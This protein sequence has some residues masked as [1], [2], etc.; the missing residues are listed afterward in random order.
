MAQFNY[1]SHWK[2]V[3]ELNDK[4]LFKSALQELDVIAEN[5]SKQQHES[6]L[7]KTYIYRIRYVAE[8]EDG[9][10]ENGQVARWKTQSFSPASRAILKSI[11]AQSL[12]SYL[13]N[14]RYELY[15][16]TDVQGD[17]SM[18]VS[19]W[20]EARLHR[21]IA[22]A[23]AASLKEVDVLKKTDISK[24]DD[25]LKEGIGGTRKLRPTL[26][27][28][29]A[30]RALDY[31]KSGE[32]LITSPENQFEVTDPA[33]FAP[34]A[35]FMK[36]AFVTTDTV[37]L[38]YKALLLLQDLMRLHA[39]EKTALLNLDLERTAYVNQVAVMPEKDASYL[40]LLKSQ[41]QAYTGEKEVTQVI[42]QLA[43]YYFT[44]S[45][46]KDATNIDGMTAS[47]AAK[48]AK[49]LCEKGVALAPGS[50]GSANCADLLANINRKYLQLQ[51]ELVNLP[52]Q[53][54]R[55]LVSYRNT[56]KIYLRAVRIDE[57]FRG[58]LRAAQNDYRDTTN[59]YWRLMLEKQPVKSW[60]QGLT[61]SDDYR[62]HAA[63][64][65]VDAL[66][67]GMYMILASAKKEFS[68]KDNMLAVQ[69]VHVSNISYILREYN[70][71]DITNKYYALHRQTGQP[72]PGTKLKVWSQTMSGN[73]EKVVLSQTY[74]AAKDGSMDVKWE[75]NRENVRL[76]W[77]NGDDD[78]FIDDHKYVYSYKYQQESD[79]MK[80][81]HSSFLF[82]DRAIYRPGQALYFKGIV[83]AKKEKG[84]RV[85][86]DMHTTVQLYDVNGELV[87]SIKV[88]T[89]E[90]G[91]YSGKFTLP[92]GRLN[93][94]FHIQEDGG[95]GYTAFN[96]EEYKRPKFYVEFEPVRGTY[97]VND[98]VKVTAKALAYAGNN[99]DGA[100]V[101]YRVV[102]RARFPYPWMMWRNPYQS[103]SREIAHG[104]TKTGADGTFNVSFAALPDLKIPASLKPIFTYEVSATVTDLNGETH[105]GEQTV[106]AGYQALEVRINLA[107]R[108]QAKDL[109]SVSIVTQNLN[110]TFEAANVALTV[111]PVKPSA[112]LLRSRYWEKPDQFIIPQAEY[113]KLFPH[114]IYK[115]E[116]EQESWARENAVLT[117]SVTTSDKSR[118]AL[119]K[120]KLAAGW[121]EVKVST[122]DKY[123]EE[124]TQ[125]QVF[126]VIDLEAK[127]PSYPVYV[128]KYSE[129]KS[130][131]PGEKKQLRIGSSAKDVYV[132]QLLQHPDKKET[133]GSF[134][135][136]GSIENKDFTAQESDRGNV[137]FQYAFVKDNRLY[138][139][140]ETVSVPWTNK[141]LD[142]T[143]ASHRDKL[144][145]GEKEKWQVTIKGY[146]G[147]KVAAEMLAS[148]YDAS[149]DEFRMQSWTAPSLNPYLDAF[150]YWTAADNF[151]AQHSI[152]RDDIREKRIPSATPFSYDE[153]DWFDW[154]LSG[155]YVLLQEKNAGQQEISIVGY[156]QERRRLMKRL[157]GR[158]AGV[159]ARSEAAMAPM[160][161]PAMAVGQER[162]I[163]SAGYSAPQSTKTVEGDMNGIDPGLLDESVVVGYGTKSTREPEAKVQP[164]KN[165]NETAF[166]L[167]DLRT[168]KEGNITFEFTVPEALTRWK[169]LSLAH[170]KD[171]AFGTAQTSIVTQKPL[172]VQPNAPRFMREGDKIEFS[173]KISNLADST[174]HGEARLELLDA[175]T[176]KPVDGWFQNI[177]PTQH[178]TVEKGQS[179]AVTFPVQIPFNFNS[180]LVYRVVAQ[181][182][183][184]SDGEGNA[185]PVLTNT[186]LVT[187]TLPLSMR[188]DGTRN[189]MMPKLLK[190]GESE[191]LHQHAFTLE[192]TANPAWYA[193]QALPYL[194]EYPY[195]CSEQIFNRYYANTL[196]T[197][198]ANALPGVKS[199]FEKWRT[200]DT[201]ALQS[202]LQKN[203]ELKSVLLQETPW[204]LEAK[205]ESEQKKRIALLF[206]LQRMS[207]EQHRAIEQLKERQLS[208]GAFPWFNGMWEDRYITQYILA[209]LGRLREV[210]ALGQK[211][212][213]G[214]DDILSKGINYADK[215]T[216]ASYH[217]LKQSKADMNAQ[218]IGYIETHYLYTRSL[219]KG[220]QQLPD[221]FRESYQY[222]ITQAKK[223]WTKMDIYPQAMLAFVFNRS[224]D[225]KT[226]M[227]I[228]RSL[229][230]R[231][232]INP[233][234]GMTWKELRG[235]YWWY[236]APVESQAML[237]AAFKEV[238]NDSIA[239]GDMKTWLLKNKQTNSWNTTKSTADACYAM[240][241]GGSNWLE[242][243][244]EVTIKAGSITVSSTTEKSEAGTGYFKKQLN[245]TEVKSAMGN[246]AVTVKGSKG[247]P[248]WGAAYW[249]YFEQ[250]DKIT[251]AETPL[252][253]EKQLFI[254][255][256]TGNG[257]VL[258]AIEDGNSL[259]VGDKVKVRV[260]MRV[261]RD[262]EYVHLKDMRAACFE[263]ENVISDSKWQNGVSYYESTKDASTNFFFSSL[264]KGTYVFEY[265]LFVTHQGNFSNGIS[266]AQCM[267]APEFSAHSEG[268]RVKVT[269]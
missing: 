207:S 209:G 26:Y 217:R 101:T 233:E 158:A 31:Y 7:L 35:V 12:L 223:Y 28:L 15:N 230:E 265:T 64:I 264:P 220:Q 194:M 236:E 76:E 50:V 98:S 123:G 127:K 148:M 145:P 197:Y 201:A 212:L 169:F 139:A 45:N 184:Y 235:G 198:I 25:I 147:E 88:S 73:K 177:F 75:N 74:T 151:K 63:E 52:D 179:T 256:N 268:I 128:W 2:K 109:D 96:V 156:D 227:D 99:I 68:L 79:E 69:F 269:E 124:V 122:K 17:T 241:L 159:V 105:S 166:F 249:Q 71:S 251:G 174:L 248:S 14:N 259:K 120:Q 29:L 176:M 187:E 4:N 27:D 153:I 83:L 86:A 199:M 10:P 262:M 78:L 102:R 164:R 140:S 61:G 6:Q 115:D 214:A 204:V 246:I 84:S 111:S 216:D 11:Q 104:D 80:D 77:I 245:T 103:V 260:V 18:D 155:A 144:Q 65:K 38:Q 87:D 211:E 138:T 185:L 32:S 129:I 237:I 9:I 92:T 70:E 253:L 95:E 226:A 54:F 3:K 110:G 266:T 224:G 49:A 24:Y 114:D 191:T 20:S 210:G 183:K 165:F 62:S 171:A 93:G 186:M 34:A 215:A 232:I 229:K 121:Y 55:T 59:R 30:H 132:L 57:D 134:A 66:P 137:V 118:V 16:R 205:N 23:Y 60:E 188:G 162:E 160:P 242:A 195:E 240:L 244:P 218:Q 222:Y 206:D 116:N 221:E 152:L 213:E 8:V 247:Q 117:Q 175:T 163:V 178:F 82:T 146:K 161:A 252:K 243:T 263:P 85:V 100:K 258:T 91:T 51:T 202:N 56:D 170:T 119:G 94:E 189:F 108:V 250:L 196:A 46:K 67:L 135:I 203:E 167:P 97:R 112:R 157:S 182:G 200:T 133:F 42:A 219:L 181:A 106:N 1:D 141:D 180:L 267:Y 125:K 231:A 40:A 39:N 21:E 154:Y 22:A 193:V 41:E 107:E 43:G 228:I 53:P 225:S 89:G 44:E 190:S 143:I 13:Q 168:D 254:Q 126:E 19:T 131:E 208:S 5:A 238:S 136:N 261:D 58:A 239:V 90:F 257:P 130:L 81:K 36:H 172:M 48:K 255:K 142:I 173:A 47:Q 234:T 149:L 150:R 192:F 72:L 113:E 33:A 37:S